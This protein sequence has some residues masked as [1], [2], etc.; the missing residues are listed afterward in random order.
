MSLITKVFIP[1]C[2]M[3]LSEDVIQFLSTLSTLLWASW[4]GSHQ[5]HLAEQITNAYQ[6][7]WKAAGFTLFMMQP[8]APKHGEITGN[9]RYIKNPQS[10]WSCFMF[11][12]N[13]Q[14]FLPYIIHHSIIIY[15]PNKRTIEIKTYPHTHTHTNKQNYCDFDADCHD[16]ALDLSPL[17]RSR[18]PKQS[19]YWWAHTWSP[20]TYTY[21]TFM[22]AAHIHTH[23]IMQIVARGGWHLGGLKLKTS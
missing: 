21:S 13:L 11:K 7:E 12:W 5:V 8:S 20:I 16:A 9:R 23:T 2:N 1:L 22:H 6:S 10:C 14:R 3:L 4:Q 15:K 17:S 19:I 18:S